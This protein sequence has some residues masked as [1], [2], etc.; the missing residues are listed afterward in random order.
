MIDLFEAARQLQVFCDQQGWQSCFIGGIALAIH[1]LP[2]GRGSVIL[3]PSRDRQGVG[4]L[5]FA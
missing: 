1:R 4:A 2:Y 5:G 3:F